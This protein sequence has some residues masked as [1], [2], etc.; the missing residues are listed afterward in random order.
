[1]A[2]TQSCFRQKNHIEYLAMENI[3]SAS[4]TSQGFGKT[5]LVASNDTVQGRQQNRR[6]ELVVSGE[7]I[8][9]TTGVLS[10]CLPLALINKAPT[11]DSAGPSDSM[12]AGAFAVSKAAKTS[13]PW[14]PKR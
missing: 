8:G 4:M 12:V 1:M 7:V 3:P 2:R 6:V 5:R 13:L 9:T 10:E 14:L 11:A